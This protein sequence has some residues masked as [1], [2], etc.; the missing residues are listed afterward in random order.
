[1]VNKLYEKFLIGNQNELKKKKLNEK[2]ITFTI[3]ESN[4][5]ETLQAFF[6]AYEEGFVKESDF[7][8]WIA[9]IG[10]RDDYDPN[11]MYERYKNSMSIITLED[12]R[13]D[14]FDYYDEGNDEV[15]E[16]SMGDFAKYV[17]ENFDVDVREIKG[18]WY[19]LVEE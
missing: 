6:M 3:D 5:F 12:F 10:M 1:M 9:D 7:V 4:Y 2:S 11:S 15:Y 16:M 8:D 13:E 17:E 14:K 19:A 18:K